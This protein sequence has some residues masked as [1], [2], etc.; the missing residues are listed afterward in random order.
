M[1]RRCCGSHVGLASRSQVPSHLGTLRSGRFCL[2]RASLSTSQSKNPAL[3]GLFL[4]LDVRQKPH[5]SR[6]FDRRFHS[7][8]LLCGEAGSLATHYATVR[9]YELLEQ[10]DI[11]V[12][13]VLDVILCQNVCHI[14]CLER[15]VV[16]INIIFR[17]INA[18]SC[19]WC[20]SIIHI[21]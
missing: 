12:V 15:N 20:R 8:L 2:T 19:G 14:F 16:R 1:S 11:L 3:A 18:R 13:Y 17:V 4:L 5:K 6:A 21:L 10:V 9:I 7:T